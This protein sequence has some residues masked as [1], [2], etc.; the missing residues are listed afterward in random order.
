MKTVKLVVLGLAVSS[1]FSLCMVLP[2]RSQ[3]SS[4]GPNSQG[5]QT[6]SPGATDPGVRTGRVNAGTPLPTLTSAQL[7][8]FLDGLN[9]FQQVDQVASGLGPTFNSNSCSSCHAQ[10]AVGGT[11]PSM[12]QYPN[13]GS[14]PQIEAATAN[15]ATNTIPFFIT[16]D[17]PVREARF[18][19]VVSSSGTVTGTPDAGVHALFTITGRA[20]ATGSPNPISSRCSNSTTSSFGSRR[21]SSAQA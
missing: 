6:A 17:G 12:S 2:I 21:H 16:S 19:F 8:Y 10:P 11:S 5:S 13:I 18:P 1:L 3:Q 7:Q 20:D 14:N 4:G 15:G 9:R